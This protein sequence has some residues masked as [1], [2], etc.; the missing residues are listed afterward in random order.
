M[1]SVI[2]VSRGGGCAVEESHL[3]IEQAGS[4]ARRL[5]EAWEQAGCCWG[6][7]LWDDEEEGNTGFLTESSHRG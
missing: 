7:G 6:I 2:R 1:A 3:T 4:V 5:A